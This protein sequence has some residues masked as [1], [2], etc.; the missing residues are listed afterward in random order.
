MA[1]SGEVELDNEER[2]TEEK[3]NSTFGKN[4]DIP[5]LKYPEFRLLIV[6]N[7]FQTGFDEPLSIHVC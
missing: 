6:S 3:L 7:K 2:Y 4:G 1:F 5:T